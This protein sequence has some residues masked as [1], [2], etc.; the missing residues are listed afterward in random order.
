MK[1][2]KGSKQKISIDLRNHEKL[3]E[4]SFGF[5]LS[6]GHSTANLSNSS[7]RQKFAIFGKFEYSPKWPFS[8]TRQT[9]QVLQVLHKFGESGKFGEFS[10]CRLDHFIHIKYVICA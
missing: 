3:F 10:E 1:P 6:N 9:R 5:I 2:C 4:H 8:E 7:T